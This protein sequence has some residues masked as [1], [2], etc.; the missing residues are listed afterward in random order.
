MRH[1][2]PQVA[3]HDDEGHLVI[4]AKTIAAHYLQWRFWVDLLTTVPFDW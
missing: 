4:D 3:F 1:Q 2:P